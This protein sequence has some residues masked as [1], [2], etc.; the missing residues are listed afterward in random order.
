MT[1]TLAPNTPVSAITPI[2]TSTATPIVSR[3]KYSQPPAA[4]SIPRVTTITSISSFVGWYTQIYAVRY[5]P[6]ITDELERI[7]VDYMCQNENY[8]KQ[9]L[10]KKF[11][12]FT[13]P[14]YMPQVNYYFS[15]GIG[16]IAFIATGIILNAITNKIFPA[17]EKPKKP[18]PLAIMDAHQ[19]KKPVPLPLAIAPIK[20]AIKP[21][22][23]HTLEEL[24]QKMAHSILCDAERRKYLHNFRGCDFW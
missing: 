5:L 11:T 21:V 6:T 20:N 16:F 9:Y 1:I 3:K 18:L 15:L 24:T 2:K 23:T 13:S 7:I 8:T 4:I 14:G 22:M 17:K 10:C 19:I 12:H